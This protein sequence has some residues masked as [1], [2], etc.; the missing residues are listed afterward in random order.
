MEYC[1]GRYGYIAVCLFM[2]IFALGAMFGTI[3]YEFRTVISTV[4]DAKDVLI[5]ITI[6]WIAY[7]IIIG[8]TVP[9]VLSNFLGIDVERN[10]VIFI[11]GLFILGL[12][13]L[14]GTSYAS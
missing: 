13:L 3:Q 2:A 10:L 9:P 5:Q 11:V 7:L 4:F 6:L 8:D 12:C 14:K 1:F